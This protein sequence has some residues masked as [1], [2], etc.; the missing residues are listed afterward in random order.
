MNLNIKFFIIN[1]FIWFSS[2]FIYAQDPHFT[3]FYN[4]PLTVNP[5]Y[6][7]VFNTQGSTTNIRVLSNYRSQWN[8]SQS[9]Y[10]TGTLQFDSKLGSQVDGNV[11]QNIFNLGLSCMYDQSLN[12]AFKSSYL[13]GTGSLHL[14]VGVS[15]NNGFD[16]YSKSLGL[17][18]GAVYGNRTI[19]L[20]QISFSQQ[21]SSGGFNLALPN[22]EIGLNNLKPFLSLNA[23][24]LYQ[25]TSGDDH[26]KEFKIG[27]SG[28]HLNKPKQTFF[29]DPMQVIPMRFSFQ[30]EYLKRSTT[31]YSFLETKLIYQYQQSIN[32]L[33]LSAIYNINIGGMNYENSIGFGA[34]YRLNDAISPYLALAISGFRFG[35]SYDITTSKLKTGLIP[36]RSMEVSMQFILSKSS[37]NE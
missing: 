13:M 15:G 32:Y 10:N 20:S 14:P 8:N 12:G 19:D 9:P 22:G 34:N 30:M 26:E 31:N 16:G 28:Y 33:L 29:D 11:I 37:G 23:G 24:L 18:F 25:S 35:C 1:I 21:F 7:G 3:Q 17:G 5:A 36:A 6:T 2:V 27:I 4:S